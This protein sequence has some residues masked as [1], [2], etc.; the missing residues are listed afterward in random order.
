MITVWVN[1]QK[2]NPLLSGLGFLLSK[3]LTTFMQIYSFEYSFL[4]AF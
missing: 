4:L 2:P 3:Y 1:K